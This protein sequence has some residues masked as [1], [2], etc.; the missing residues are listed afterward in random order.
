MLRVDV[1]DRVEGWLEEARR[2]HGA[3]QLTDEDFEHLKHLLGS[4]QPARQEILYLQASST[5]PISRVVG[6][7]LYRPGEVHG[8]YSL[9][10]GEFPY[11]NVMAA[12]EDGWRVVQFPVP[13]TQFSDHSVDYVGFEFVLERYS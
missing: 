9:E 1:T 3:G 11:N 2:K 7:A 4:G 6:M 12:V 13:P 5:S 8:S 10:S